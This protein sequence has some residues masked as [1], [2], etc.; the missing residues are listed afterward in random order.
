M[1]LSS[2][3]K[4]AVEEYIEYGNSNFGFD[5]TRV[6]DLIL[7]LLNERKGCL[8]GVSNKQDAKFIQ[9]CLSKADI[10]FKKKRYQFF[11]ASSERHLT[12]P[13]G[14]GR[15]NGDFFGYPESAIEF[16]CS[17]DDPVAEFDSFLEETQDTVDS[18]D[19]K[20]PLIGYIPEPSKKGLKEALERQQQYERALR[21][22]SV[23]LGE[24]KYYDM[25][26]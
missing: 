3:E 4:K 25:Q 15:P 5:A 21:S 26:I 9:E 13:I 6:F 22:C 12:S 14:E 17:S 1:S 7:V 24:V 8:I 16:Y 2:K 10:P 20:T 23:D 11:I 18:W 19:E